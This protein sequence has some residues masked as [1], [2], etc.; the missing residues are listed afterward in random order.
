MSVSNLSRPLLGMSLLGIAHFF[1]RG[2]DEQGLGFR[3]SP[4]S[5]TVPDFTEYS[6]LE[7]T[8][9]DHEVQVLSELGSQTRSD[10]KNIP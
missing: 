8:H 3:S 2:R 1:G 6:D 9:K 10:M 4:S 5:T 7:G